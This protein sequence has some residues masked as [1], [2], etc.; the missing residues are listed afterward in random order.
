M[1]S[2]RKQGFFVLFTVAL[3]PMFTGCARHSKSEHYYLVATNTGVPYWKSAGDGFNKAATDYGV[4]A[5]MRGPKGFDPQAEVAEFK[6]VVALK[7]AGILV[8]VANSQLMMPEINA[9]IDAGIPVI[10]MDSDSPESKRLYFIG[11]NNLEAGHLGGQRV[12]ARLNGKG[13][14]VFITNPGQPNLQ[15]RL[16]G[17]KEIFDGYPG[18]KVV[19]VFDMQGDSGL[20][21]DKTEEYLGRTGADRVDA[22]VCLESTSAK[23]VGEVLKRK[24]VKDRLLIGMDLAVGTLLGVQDGTID[25]TISQKPYT[26]GLLGLKALDEVHHSKMKKFTGDYELDPFSPFPAFVDTGVSLVDKSNVGPMLERTRAVEL[27]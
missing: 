23:D 6:S 19:D 7:P 22:I 16:K 1:I 8:S 17:Y 11:T 15:E 27:E 2:L 5:E 21:M 24:N 12:A 9:A 4:T 13:N 20:A 26:M 18:I 3:L 14:V 10:T 25:S